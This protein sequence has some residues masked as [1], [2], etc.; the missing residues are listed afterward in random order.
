MSHYIDESDVA[1]RL[2]AQTVKAIYDDDNNGAADTGPI[3]RLILDAESYV[4]GRAL[5]G[6]YDLAACRAA[7]PNEIVR[8]CLD[9]AEM[10]AA[11]RHP[12]YV[13]RD[14]EPLKKALDADL[15][16]LRTGK[17][18]LDV[19]STPE[20]AKNEGG[21]VRSGDPAAPEPKA[22][23]FADGTGLF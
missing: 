3:A 21:T 23:R 5:R 19:V 10:Y 11:K 16:A 1:D 18:R 6:I 2:S 8:L 4:E 12:E 7:P 22:K 17:A 9:A 13:R 20:P 15:D 14:W